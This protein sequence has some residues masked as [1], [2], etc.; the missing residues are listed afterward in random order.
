[1][2]KYNQIRVPTGIDKTVNDNKACVDII[3]IKIPNDKSSKDVCNT[4]L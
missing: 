2:L 4:H 1:M 3:V